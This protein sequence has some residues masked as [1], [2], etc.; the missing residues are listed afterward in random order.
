MRVLI[1][2][3]RL[4]ALSL[5]YSDFTRACVALHRC[6]DRNAQRE[7]EEDCLVITLCPFSNKSSLEIVKTR[8]FQYIRTLI[9][10]EISIIYIPSLS[11]TSH[12]H[13]HLSFNLAEMSNG[14]LEN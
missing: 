8:S 11:Q 6:A 9:Q 13:I 14:E 7:A 3:N 1:H 10:L 4:F 12:T 5:V 2:T